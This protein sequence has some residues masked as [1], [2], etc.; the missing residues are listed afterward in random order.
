[1]IGRRDLLKLSGATLAF[2]GLAP[3]RYVLVC[4]F[5]DVTDP[6]FT[7]HIDKGMIAE[8]TVQ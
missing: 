3:G 4:F 7:G 8:F 1:M 6:E 5:P 2:S